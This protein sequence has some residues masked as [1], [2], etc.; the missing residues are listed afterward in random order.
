MDVVALGACPLS[1][2][3]TN[4]EGYEHG[5]WMADGGWE[6]LQ[7]LKPFD[8]WMFLNNYQKKSELL[9]FKSLKMIFSKFNVRMEIWKAW[10]ERGLVQLLKGTN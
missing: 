6:E 10:K 3:V 1:D 5:C 2:D 9:F 7:N 8:L 4:F